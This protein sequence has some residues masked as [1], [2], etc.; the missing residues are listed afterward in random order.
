MAKRRS[1]RGGR[2]VH[3]KPLQ[4]ALDPLIAPALV[5]LGQADDQ[6]LYRWVQR[7]RPPGLAVRVGPC[8]GDQPQV[9]AQQRVGLHEKARPAFSG[10]RAAEGAEQGPVGGLQSG[11]WGV[12]TQDGELVAQDQDLQ[13]LGG[14]AA[15][16][17]HEHLNGA[18]QRKVGEVRQHQGDLAVGWLKRHATEPRPARTGSSQ[19][20]SEFAYPTGL[21]RLFGRNQ[22]V[23]H[24][25]HQQWD[26]QPHPVIS[27]I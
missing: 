26:L 17:Q 7:R 24:Q 13:V 23:H 8:A 9:P 3:T 20:T 12:A 16:E 10:Q 19:P 25:P 27:K 18:A 21:L 11:T 4:L 14:I 5:L 6:L 22:R 1:D 15:G 2:D